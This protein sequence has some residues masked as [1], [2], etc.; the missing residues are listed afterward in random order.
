M[1]RNNDELD[2]DIDNIIERLENINVQ[3]TQLLK[4]ELEYEIKLQE[5]RREQ[6]HRSTAQNAEE[7]EIRR[8]R[9]GKEIHIGD[10]VRFLTRGVFRANVGTVKSFGKRFVV[11]TG[12]QGFEVNRLAKNLRVIESQKQRR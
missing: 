12:E 11:S 6:R 10:T 4:E 5:L 7:E 1:N 8:D 9:D 3:R 2:R